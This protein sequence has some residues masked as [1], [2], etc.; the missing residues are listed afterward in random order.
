MLSKSTAA[1]STHSA[2]H[3]ITCTLTQFTFIQAWPTR[4]NEI[5]RI[6]TG[7]KWQHSDKHRL[8]AADSKEEQIYWSLQNM[9]CIRVHNTRRKTRYHQYWN[10]L[11]CY[12]LF[13]PARYHQFCS[14]N[15]LAI[16]VIHYNANTKCLQLKKK[17]PL[18]YVLKN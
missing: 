1:L 12:I 11:L 6:C 18:L 17:P 8:S 4:H 9:P 14:C 15:P 3:H 16:I 2:N 7:I 10:T 13:V 5:I